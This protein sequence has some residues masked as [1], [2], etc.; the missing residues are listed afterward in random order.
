MKQIQLFLSLQLVVTVIVIVAFVVVVVVVSEVIVVHVIG[1]IGVL[2]VVL[3]IVV[4]VDVHRFL[5]LTFNVKKKFQNGV[6][7]V[8]WR[9]PR[10]HG[11][12][13]SSSHLC[14]NVFVELQTLATVGSVFVPD[15]KTQAIFYLCGVYWG[16]TLTL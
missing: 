2:V 9:Q 13:G 16:S 6:L 8:R 14:R 5:F 4:A 3:D 11:G 1:V 7:P 10:G 15:I 12:N